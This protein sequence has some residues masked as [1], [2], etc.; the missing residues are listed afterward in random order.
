MKITQ[1]NQ[2]HLI[3]KLCCYFDVVV[4][5]S[6]KSIIFNIFDYK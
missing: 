1:E 5:E 3:K 6:Q 2:F 4:L